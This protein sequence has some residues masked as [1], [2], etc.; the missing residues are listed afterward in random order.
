MYLIYAL[1]YAVNVQ[2]NVYI[3]EVYKNL[4]TWYIHDSLYI[5]PIF[6]SFSAEVCEEETSDVTHVEYMGQELQGKTKNSPTWDPV[7][8]QT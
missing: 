4:H 7:Y 2:C 5:I 8:W 6:I 1:I 3:E